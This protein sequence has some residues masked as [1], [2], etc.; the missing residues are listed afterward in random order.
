MSD[1]D[2]GFLHALLQI[3]EQHDC[4]FASDLDAFRPHT[5]VV[6]LQPGQSLFES[7]G[8]LVDESERGLFFIE[9]GLM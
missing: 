1:A 7:S 2:D 9:F 8:G 6:E 5:S 3:D 4:D